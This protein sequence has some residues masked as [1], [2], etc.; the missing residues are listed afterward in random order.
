[1]SLFEW[2]EGF[3]RRYKIDFIKFLVYGH[4]SCDETVVH[5]LLLFDT[6]FIDQ[7]NFEYFSDQYTELSKKIFRFIQSVDDRHRV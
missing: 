2:K 5:L 7:S 4:S 6:K 1:M 3:G